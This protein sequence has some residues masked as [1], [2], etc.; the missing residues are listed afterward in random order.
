MHNAVIQLF[1]GNLAS[2]ALGLFREVL[3]AGLL[4]TGQAIGAFR[5]AQTGTFT[6]VNFFTSDSL[7]SAFIPQYKRFITH[8]LDK[9]QTLFW[10]LCGIF[11]LLSLTIAFA[12]WVGGLH[13]VSTLAPGLEPEATTLAVS[14][15]RVMALGVPFYLMSALLMFLGMASNDFIPM[16]IRPVVQNVGMIAGVLLAFL[17]RDMLL[18]AWGFTASYIAFSIWVLVRCLRS[19]YLSFPDRWDWPQVR[20]V[21]HAFWSTLR[22]LLLLPV[23]L[24]G[25]IIV[26]RAV[27]SLI[28]LVAISALDYARFVSETLIL[29]VSVPVAFAGLAHWSG[30]RGDEV[31]RRLNR[32]LL[33]MLVVAV[34]ASVFLAVHAHIVVD[35]IYARGAFDAESVRVTGDI[36]FGIAAGLWAQVIGYVLI[37]ALNAQMR[38]NAVVW[39]M[40]AALVANIAVNLTIYPYLGAMTLGLGNSLYGLVLLAG[41]LTALGLWKD[42]AKGGG[43]RALGTAGYLLLDHLLPLPSGAWRSLA[44]ASVFALIYWMAWIALVPLLRNAVIE[45]TAPRMRRKH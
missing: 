33:L 8:S 12:L 10:S 3:T 44:A 14:M 25:N 26:E 21:V 2:K 1:T 40:A 15:L 16:A 30:L 42:A 27:A 5:V 35:V 43:M 23:M 45:A 4:G 9:A 31:R 13:W 6:P 7:N 19:G 36:L 37:K 22:P 11:G 38:N 39:V 32:V 17:M 41:A 28:G 24:Q 29:L 34:P 20:E 18:L